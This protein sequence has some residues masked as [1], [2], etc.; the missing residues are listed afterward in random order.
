MTEDERDFLVEE[1]KKSCVGM[2]EIGCCWGRSS[3]EIGSIAKENELRLTCI[4]TWKHQAFYE[5][6][7]G[8]IAEAGL[9][10]ITPIRSK[11]ND[12]VFVGDAD[13]LFIDGDHSYEGVKDDWTNWSPLLTT[14]AIVVFHDIE[15]PCF[16][17]KQLFGE[18]C[19]KYEF[20]REGNIGAI[21][22]PKPKKRKM[23]RSADKRIK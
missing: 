15:V 10:N 9:D 17:V 22:I 16:G 8:N 2:I 3:I 13:F 4:D 18:L 7:L 5:G 14:P 20:S 6:F 23:K 12:V 1:A 11:S 21:Y 19:E